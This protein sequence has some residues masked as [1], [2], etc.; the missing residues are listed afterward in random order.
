GHTLIHHSSSSS[1]PSQHTLTVAIIAFS[2]LMSEYRQIGV[3]GLFVSLIVG[4]SRIYMGVHFPFDVLGSFVVAFVIV[5][6]VNILI[7]RFI[8]KSKQPITVQ[9]V[10]V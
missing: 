8:S 10:D 6:S 2:F 5:F 7:K 4:W 1:M 9:A 3:F